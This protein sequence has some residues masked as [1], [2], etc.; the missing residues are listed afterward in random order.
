MRLRSGQVIFVLDE[1]KNRKM[2]INSKFVFLFLIVLLFSTNTPLHAIMPPEAYSEQT[3]ISPIKIIA[4][5]EK[6]ED[7]GP[8]GTPPCAYIKKAIFKAERIFEGTQE[9]IF[10]GTFL[11]H[12]EGCTKLWVGP[13]IY[14]D[15]LA[16]KDR[17]FV[18]ISKAGEITSYA[19]IT[20][21]LEEVLANAP[22]KLRAFSWGIYLEIDNDKACIFK[23]KEKHIVDK[24]SKTRA[25]FNT[26]E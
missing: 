20:P 4:T 17:V 18:T 21:E 7:I 13:Q 15:N 14:Y 9:K 23:G 24:Q 5:V 16:V 8:A 26:N 3:S 10:T 1:I 19:D 6:V 11:T 25:L 12:I 2:K 22:D